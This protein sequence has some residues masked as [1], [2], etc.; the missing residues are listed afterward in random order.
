MTTL[1]CVPAVVSVESV[2]ELLDA[3]DEVVQCGNELLVYG[4]AIDEDGR[5]AEWHFWVSL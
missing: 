5:I 1:M 3:S 2:A 4:D